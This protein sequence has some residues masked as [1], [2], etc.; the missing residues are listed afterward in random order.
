MEIEERLNNIEK[1]LENIKALILFKKD[2][3]EGKRPVSLRGLGKIL[4]SE[5]ELDKS[6]EIAK[7]SIFSGLNVLRD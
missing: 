6:I 5:E 3:I 2:L 1:E 7:K 4:V